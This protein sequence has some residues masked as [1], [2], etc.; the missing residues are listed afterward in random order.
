MFKSKDSQGPSTG[1]SGGNIA[2]GGRLGANDFAKKIDQRLNQSNGRLCR[3]DPS[4]EYID[5]QVRNMNFFR[6]ITGWK[7]KEG[8]S[9]GYR[10]GD[11]TSVSK[12]ATPLKSKLTIDSHV[13]EHSTPLHSFTFPNKFNSSKD[14]AIKAAQP[15]ILFNSW[16][17]STREVLGMTSKLNRTKSELAKKFEQMNQA[18]KINDKKQRSISLTIKRAED[19]DFNSLFETL[20]ARSKNTTPKSRITPSFHMPISTVDSRHDRQ[21]L[22]ARPTMNDYGG[23]SK[24]G[25]FKK[26]QFHSSKITPNSSLIASNA[27]DNKEK[28]IRTSQYFLLGLNSAIPNQ[29][30]SS[31]NTLSN[32]KHFRSK[33]MLSSSFI[34]FK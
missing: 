25:F 23:L 32:S 21:N 3:K 7:T 22:F 15:S 31:Q 9:N 8:V 26:K 5:N 11:K 10:Y 1:S 29:L 6:N 4:F 30:G 24:G 14:V 28:E 18:R 19:S 2:Y 27:F 17:A 33:G 20:N 13:S 12:I 34:A 16:G